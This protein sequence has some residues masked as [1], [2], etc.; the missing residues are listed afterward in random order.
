MLRPVESLVSTGLLPSG[1]G[2]TLRGEMGEMPGENYDW[3]E[4]RERLRQE[5]DRG[6]PPAWTPEEPDEEIFGVFVGFNPQAPTK[7]YGPAPV[8]ELEDPTGTRWSV[9]LLHKVLRL[10][11]E[12]QRPALGERILIRYLGKVRPDGGGNAYDNYALVL[13]RPTS[14][15]PDWAGIA[16]RYGDEPL[17]E[18]HRPPTAA[19]R[20]DAPNLDQEDIPF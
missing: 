10:H 8:V 12:R 1:P 4:V 17:D 11:F 14:G 18:P 19:A 9:W 15:A 2:P 7:L 20:S 16:Q 13:D 5:A 6:F 3:D